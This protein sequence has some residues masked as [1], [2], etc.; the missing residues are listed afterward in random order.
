MKDVGQING[1]LVYF[2]AISFFMAIWYS[3]WS[4]WYIFLVLVF[5]TEK[6]LAALQIEDNALFSTRK[7]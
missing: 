1:H 6:N 7:M 4:V 3:L 5:C 2:T